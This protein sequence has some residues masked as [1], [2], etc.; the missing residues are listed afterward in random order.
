LSGQGGK[1][2]FSRDFGSIIMPIDIS[3]EATTRLMIR[4]YFKA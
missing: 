4:T 2:R 3:T 1:L